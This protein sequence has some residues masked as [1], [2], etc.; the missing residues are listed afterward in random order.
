MKKGPPSSNDFAPW[1]I[2]CEHNV[3]CALHVYVE[4]AGTKRFLSTQ[5]VFPDTGFVAVAHTSQDIRQA[6][7]LVTSGANNCYGQLVV[8]GY[9]VSKHPPNSTPDSKT[10]LC[11]THPETA[12]T[13]HFLCL[14][15]VL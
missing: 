7:R 5:N 11:G 3:R 4:A 8:L 13:Y 12:L 14:E 10:V 6:I 15:N 1:H 2:P 9:K